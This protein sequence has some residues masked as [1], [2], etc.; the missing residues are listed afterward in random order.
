MN[1]VINLHMR[2][3]VTSS[4]KFSFST[5][6]LYGVRFIPGSPLAARSRA[7]VRSH[8]WM[9]PLLWPVKMN[10]RGRDPMRL[11]PSHSWT[12]NDV[13]VVPSTALITHTLSESE[14]CFCHTNFHMDTQDSDTKQWQDISVFTQCDRLESR[15][16]QRLQSLRPFTVFL[17]C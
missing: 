13:T 3:F 17:S 11:E 2:T 1:K 12:Q 8:I 9:A 15:P 10:L 4:G 16:E 5:T 14:V 7:V 6:L